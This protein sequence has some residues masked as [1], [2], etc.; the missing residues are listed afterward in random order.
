MKNILLLLL[1]LNIYSQTIESYFEIP[2]NYKRI[3][4]NDYHSWIISKNI[5]TK[6]HVKYFSG[7]IK[8][9]FNKVYVAKFVYDIG[10]KDLHQC[11]DAVM[12]NKAR[13]LFESKQ[14]NKISFTFSHNA[15]IY[16]ITSDSRYCLVAFPFQSSLNAPHQYSPPL[17]IS[18][19]GT[20]S[21]CPLF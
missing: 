14:Y 2:K 21:C 17:K 18:R 11:A 1:S 8:K 6:D 4:Q 10:N 20:A 19:L 16:W 7:Q 15:K 5:N 9:G 3:I 12:Y 13:Y